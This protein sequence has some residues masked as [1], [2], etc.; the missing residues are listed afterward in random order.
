MKTITSIFTILAAALLAACSPAEQASTNDAISLPV[1]TVTTSNAETVNEYP[2][3]IEGSAEVEIRPQVS[4]ILEKIFIDEGAYVSAGQPLFKINDRVYKEQYNNAGAELLAAKAAAANAQL[5]VNK[6]QP[7]VQN[8]VVSELQLQTA[9]SNYTLAAA[10]VKQAQALLADAQINIGYTLIKA[11]AAGYIGLLNKKAGSLV[12]L[13]DAKELT[14]L[15]NIKE[16]RAYFS[17]SEQ[18]FAGLKNDLPGNSIGEK[19]KNARP[20]SLILAGNDI[21]PEPGRMDMVN[22]GF[23]K[24]SGAITIRA[25]FPNHHGLL[26]SGNTGRIKLSFI[27]NDVIA[28]PQAATTTIQDKI[29]VFALGDSSKVHKQLITVAGRSGDSFLISDGLKSGDRIVLEGIEGLQDGT[30]IQPAEAKPNKVA[31]L[32]K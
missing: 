14:T 31:L 18:E 4:G 15:A 21:Y 26:R 13:S 1:A 23:D 30:K 16:V 9:Q 17:L 2:T 29:F 27:Q 19:L 7:L 3:A 22:G 10:K 32:N 25:S 12:S 11:P 24:N 5:E 20:V 8:K 28:I 6:L